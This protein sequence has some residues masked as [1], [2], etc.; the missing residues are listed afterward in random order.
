MEPYLVFEKKIFTL[1]PWGLY[2]DN[3]FQTL[4]VFQAEN[5]NI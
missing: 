3:L 5:Q 2:Q 4:M 1:K